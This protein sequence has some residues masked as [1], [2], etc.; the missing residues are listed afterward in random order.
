MH[1]LKLADP[2][3]LN[4]PLAEDYV[5]NWTAVCLVIKHFED[6]GYEVRVPHDD[7]VVHS[8]EVKRSGSGGPWRRVLVRGCCLTRYQDGGD[9][10]FEHNSAHGVERKPPGNGAQLT[11]YPFPRDVYDF[12]LFVAFIM[13]GGKAVIRQVI[14]GSQRFAEDTLLSEY[15][16]AGYWKMSIY[17]D[18]DDERVRTSTA[19]RLMQVDLSRKAA[20]DDL[21]DLRAPPAVVPGD[22]PADAFALTRRREATITNV[23][24]LRAA[25]ENYPRHLEELD[26]AEVAAALLAAVKAVTVAAERE[27]KE[28]ARAA[29]RKAQ[30]AAAAAAVVDRRRAEV[31]QTNATFARFAG[32]KRTAEDRDLA[33]KEGVA[34]LADH[35]RAMDAAAEQQKKGGLYVRVPTPPEIA[36]RLA[37]EA[38]AAKKAAE[39]REKE[40]AAVS[41][42]EDPE[43]KKE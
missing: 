30:E 33:V 40:A 36:R 42:L 22:P 1:G 18:E 2:M 10:R 37:L 41:L 24:E 15:S 20:V 17:D 38:V 31:N 39:Q 32:K 7:T 34:F 25:I 9:T 5:T 16:G 11:F 6:A 35:K 12:F 23:N 19:R 3:T 21:Y 43:I 26:A 29:A 4:T 8:L 14:S 28:E 13:V 27:A